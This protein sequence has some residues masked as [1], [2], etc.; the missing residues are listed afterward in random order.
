M[1]IG[2]A[3]RGILIGHR[4][5]WLAHMMRAIHTTS[6]AASVRSVCDGLRDRSSIVFAVRRLNSLTI[7]SPSRGLDHDAV[8][9]PDRR[10]GRHHDDGAVAIGRLHRVA[11]DFQRIGVLVI[12]R[13]ERDLVPA[14]A[15]REAAVVEI[16]AG[17]GLARPISGT[18]WVG[19]ARGR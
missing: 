16:A 3:V 8:A 9:A 12:R 6:P 19:A 14:L 10:G 13:G 11:G 5:Y 7:T 18:D 1:A 17:A 4:P 2:T 15:G